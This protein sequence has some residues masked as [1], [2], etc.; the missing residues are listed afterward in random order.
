MPNPLNVAWLPQ[1]DGLCGAACAQMILNAQGKAGSDLATLN[2]LWSDIKT[3]TIPPGPNPA[4]SPV[5]ACGGFGNQICEKCHP[6]LSRFCWCTHPSALAA[7]I[8]MHLR[9]GAAAAISSDASEDVITARAI[10]S[11]NN[12]L[13]AAVLVHFGTHWVVVFGYEPTVLGPG[14][15]ATHVMIRDSEHGDRIVITMSVWANSYLTP[16]RCGK[17][18]QHFVTVGAGA[19]VVP[20]V[21]MKVPRV[22][23]LAPIVHPSLIEAQARTSAAWLLAEQNWVAALRDA[24][25]F[26]PLLVHDLE[27]SGRDYY[28]VDFRTG[29]RPTARMLFDARVPTAAQYAGVDG[30]DRELPR[31]VPPED[32]LRTVDRRD[33]AYRDSTSLTIDVGAVDA[34]PRLVWK[35][36]DQS[37][38]PFRPFYQI[39]QD[40][41][42]V[43]LRADGVLFTELTT[44]GAGA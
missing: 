14:Q 36:C 25:A 9:G 39:Q 2:A 42:V 24:K 34:P 7:T 37:H 8:N 1:T 17:L 19:G 20:V 38:S 18:K 32:V 3:N 16:P 35:A 33:A 27:S 15:T 12:G 44:S 4:G 10:A 30:P 5:P 31:F 40:R 22:D 41:A 26:T 6:P 13:A 29:D 43:Y 23:A 28:L 11:V 21:H